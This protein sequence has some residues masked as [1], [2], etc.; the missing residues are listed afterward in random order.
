VVS[1]NDPK[2]SHANNV[3]KLSSG[4]T[5]NITLGATEVST[6]AAI[7]TNTTGADPISWNFTPVVGSPVIDRGQNV[8]IAK[9]FVGN[10]VPSVPNSGILETSS[11]TGTLGASATGGAISC[12]G[13]TTTITVSATGGTAPYTGTGTFTV[14]AG[15]YNYTV[16]DAAGGSTTTS[17]TVSQPAAIAATVITGT[18]TVYGGSTNVTVTAS[19]G[20][21]AYSYKL[22]SG[23]Y[24]ASNT[25]TGVTAGNHSVT[26][27]D[28]NGCTFVKS[29]TLTQPAA[30]ATLEV[31]ATAGTISCNGGSATVIV[32]ATGGTNSLY[33]YW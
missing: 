28:A 14:S 12:N 8:G 11:G 22:N 15:T 29:F 24:Q 21:G 27:K 16:T 23:V 3:Y 33:R 6:S 2:T 1:S 26:I 9:D 17:V 32:S 20:T 10:P 7:F 5:A 4:S 30:P 19:G 18:I 25:F 31:L 13:G